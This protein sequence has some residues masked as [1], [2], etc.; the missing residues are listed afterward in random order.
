[1]LTG[2]KVMVSSTYRDLIE[3][4]TAVALT[5]AGQGMVPLFMESDAA[6]PNRGILENSLKMVAEAKAKGAGMVKE[7]VTKAEQP[8]EAVIGDWETARALGDQVA[9]RE[10]AEND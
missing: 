2:K 8:A 1:M 10:A 7:A 3:E 9:A 5:I 6:I 4:R